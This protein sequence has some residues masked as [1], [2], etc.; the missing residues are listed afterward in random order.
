MVIITSV[1]ADRQFVE[2]YNEYTGVDTVDSVIFKSHLPSWCM[3]VLLHNLS[4]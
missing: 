1:V 2:S 3:A 4:V